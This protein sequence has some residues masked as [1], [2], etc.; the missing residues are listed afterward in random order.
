MFKI[1]L[2]AK[3]YKEITMIYIITHNEFKKNY[4]LAKVG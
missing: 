4:Y 2:S 3:D 1:N